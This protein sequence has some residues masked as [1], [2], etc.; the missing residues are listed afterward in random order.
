M[1]RILSAIFLVIV[2]AVPS[3]FGPAWAFFIVALLVIPWCMF[4][5]YRVVLN[6]KAAILGWIG[7]IASLPFLGFIYQGNLQAAYFTLSLASIAVIL[8]ALFLFERDRTGA[9]DI[10]YAIAG[11][12]YPLALTSF[13]VLLRNG[14]D[15][16]FWLVFAVVGVFGSDV[17]AY[18]TG[19]NLGRHR[20]APKLS[21]K[22]T[23]E[24]FI[25]G[26][27]LSIVLGQ[28]AYFI[29]PQIV[30]LERSYPTLLLALLS[31][32]IGMLDLAGDLT[33]SL[34]KRDFNIKDM[35]HIIPGHGGM[36]DRM[37]GVILVGC[38]LYLVLKVAG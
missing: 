30:P 32:C 19:K 6:P 22:K 27:C 10:V 25:G 15:G 37:D 23:V 3:I 18:Y 31:A 9:K 26:I 21:P 8:T 7:L 1:T 33:A 16:R 28:L 38:L 35:G 14:I 5:L 11:L 36:L 24:G 17:G 12:I 2:F 20:I 29:Y 34:F 13:W 4:E